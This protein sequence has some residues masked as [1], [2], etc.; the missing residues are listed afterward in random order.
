MR[1]HRRRYPERSRYPPRLSRPGHPVVEL[2]VRVI[3]REHELRDED[4]KSPPPCVA[5]AISVQPPG[6]RVELGEI[7]EPVPERSAG[8]VGLPERKRI[9]SV[10]VHARPTPVGQAHRLDEIERNHLPA[11]PRVPA[12]NDVAPVLRAS[13]RRRRR[14]ACAH[15]GAGLASAAGSGDGQWPSRAAGSGSPWTAR[16]R[17]SSGERPGSGARPQPQNWPSPA[18]AWAPSCGSWP[19]LAQAGAWLS[20]TETRIPRCRASGIARVELGGPAV[21]GIA[22]SRGLAGRVAATVGHEACTGRSRRPSPDRSETRDRGPQIDFFNDGFAAS[23][24]GRRGAAAPR[25]RPM[26]VWRDVQIRD[27][28]P[29]LAATRTDKPM[30]MPP[31]QDSGGDENCE[32]AGRE[33]AVRCGYGLGDGLLASAASDPPP[34]RWPRCLVGGAA[35]TRPT[36]SGCALPRGGDARSERAGAS[37]PAAWEPPPPWRPAEQYRAAARTPSPPGSQ[38]RRR[39]R[40]PAPS[41]AAPAADERKRPG[42]RKRPRALPSGQASRRA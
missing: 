37:P 39:P 42:R 30:V 8:Q 9:V 27:F 16:P 10:E 28:D 26:Q 12:D 22:G 41:H 32:P 19:P 18:A 3:R 31:E 17:S 1:F 21:G 40:R 35:V 33:P 24:S 5:I 36:A 34:S 20:S 6:E 15:R 23:C 25:P 14:R 4:P 38:G 13:E 2:E 29:G 11:R 7:R